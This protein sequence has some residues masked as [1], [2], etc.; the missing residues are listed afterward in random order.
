VAAVVACLAAAVLLALAAPA[1]SDTQPAPAGLATLVPDNAAA[2]SHLKLDAEG[3]G[4]GLEAGKLPSSLAFAWQKGFTIDPSAVPG[5][6]SNSQADNGQCPDSSRFA[7]GT[8]DL[9]AHGG[10]F[11]PGGSHYTANLTLYVGPPQQ[12]GDPAGAV[13]HFIEPS[14]GFSGS[15]RGRIDNLSDPTYGTEVRFDKLPLPSLPPGFTFDLQ[16]LKLDVGVIGGQS[17]APSGSGTG[18]GSGSGSGTGTTNTPG[19]RRRRHRRGRTLHIRHHAVRKA[20]TGA[21]SAAGA[22]AASASSF[23]VNPPTCSGSWSVRLQIG[24]SD[25]VQERDASAPCTS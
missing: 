7:S 12:A 3:P 23:L 17:A 20:S 10:G 18:S 14:S 4:G 8:I 2:P 6:C 16:S 21:A 19:H 5:V 24:Y 1:L 11:A 22:R 25:G 13:F 15:S 9:V